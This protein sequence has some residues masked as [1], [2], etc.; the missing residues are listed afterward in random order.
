[1]TSQ[2]ARVRVPWSAAAGCAVAAALMAAA[3][4]AE[5]ARAAPHPGA[6]QG[7]L[8]ALQTDMD[9]IARRARPSVVTVFAQ[10]LLPSETARPSGSPPGHPPE[11]GSGPGSAAV[12]A[13]GHIHTRVGSGVAVGESEILTTASVVLGAERVMI[14]TANGLQAEAEVV[15]VDPIFNV[16]LL[17]VPDVRLPE[18]PLPDSL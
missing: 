6:P 9:Q 13:P 17:R 7:L 3:A 2:H 14:R 5:G 4:L 8:S 18:V 1:M 15:G 12:P 11:G 16:A 10:T